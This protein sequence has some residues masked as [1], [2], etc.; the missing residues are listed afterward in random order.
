MPRKRG[1]PSSLQVYD[2]SND[3]DDEEEGVEEETKASSSGARR[4]KA[5]RNNQSD[6]EKATCVELN[7]AVRRRERLQGNIV[8][9][10]ILYTFIC[11]C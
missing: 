1:P 7:S 10:F 11:L 9:Y 4:M 3:I 8:V 5:S 2:C 6:A